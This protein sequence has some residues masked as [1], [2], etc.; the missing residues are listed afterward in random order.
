M[1]HFVFFSSFLSLDE[2]DHLDYSR[3]A[4][5]FKQHYHRMNDTLNITQEEPEVKENN[6]GINNLNAPAESPVDNN[7]PSSSGN[8]KHRVD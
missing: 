1:F 4:S 8:L 2:Y 6:L 3:P 7:I 5:S